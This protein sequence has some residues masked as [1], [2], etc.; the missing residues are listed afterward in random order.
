MPL[1]DVSL[2]LA[3]KNNIYIYIYIQGDSKG[4]EQN[5]IGDRRPHTESGKVGYLRSR[6]HQF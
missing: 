1:E 6:M 2:R 4:H 3:L 5:E